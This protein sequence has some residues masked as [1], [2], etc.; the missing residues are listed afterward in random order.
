ARAESA[1]GEIHAI[2]A[3]ARSDAGTMAIDQELTNVTDEIAARS[4]ED[5]RILSH[6]TSLDLFARLQSPWDQISHRLSGWNKT[7]GRRAKQ[8]QDGATHLEQLDKLWNATRESAQK[9]SVPSEL[10]DRI[11]SVL[12]EVKRAREQ[13]QAQLALVLKMQNRVTE[14]ESRVH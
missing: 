9:A 8:L 10:F 14:Q 11:D 4:E 2:E 7:L 12:T 13:V 1:L 3:Q 5:S 6:S